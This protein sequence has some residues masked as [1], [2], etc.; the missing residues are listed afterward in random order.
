MTVRGSALPTLYAIEPT[1]WWTQ[2]MLAITL[3]LLEAD[4][5]QG[6]GDVL[7]IGCGG[8]MAG[9]TVPAQHRT[10]ID[11]SWVALM[12]ARRHAGLDLVQGSL[13]AL[14]FANRQFDLILAL[15]SIDQYGVD[16]GAVVA[17]CAQMLRPGG[18][19]LIRVSAYGWLEGAHDVATGT[20]ERMVAGHLRQ[21]V[22]H[23]GLEV[24]RLTYANTALFPLAAARRLL[25]RWQGT[26]AEADLR[27]PAPWLNRA[28]R[29]V[30]HA[31]ATWLRRQDLP[32]GLS[33][34]GLAVTP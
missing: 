34:Y 17:R 33:L 29:N 23:A 31:E 11:L 22:Q 20:G 12:H 19:L 4:G 2:G 24:R 13:A 26:V 28:L 1:H 25:G 10:S 15:D 18:R 16:G 8:G 3:A 30:L 5:W 32:W 21:L 9:A 14:P 6:E 27:P 7:D